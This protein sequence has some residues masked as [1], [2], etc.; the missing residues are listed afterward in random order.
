MNAHTISLA[1]GI[2]SGYE[3]SRFA[4][5]KMPP[6]QVPLLPDQP[7][8]APVL[9]EVHPGQFASAL[10]HE[11]RNPLTTINLAVDLLQS[12]IKDVEMKI[13]L[14]IIMRSS[15]RI[16]N[17]VT[18]LLKYQQE[19]KAEAEKHSIHQLLE[20]VLEMAHD[21]ITLK[22]ITVRKEYAAEDCKIIMNRPE[23]KIALT[24]IVMNAIDAMIPGEGEL[25]LI[26]RSVFGKYIVRI[27]DNG[28]GISK[29]N[30]QLI[31]K[32]YFTSKPG[33]LGL[34]LA[35]T[36]DALRSNHIAVNVESEEG[37]GTSFIL[38]LDKIM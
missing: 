9:A 1:A 4:P 12:G 19:A 11:V 28:C 21:R 31:F 36:Y 13:Y 33:G 22:R 2:A 26:T 3:P 18:E 23:I 5:W 15:E 34:G 10:A 24:N 27:E 38:F 30:L 35:T 7:L 8:P 20:E 37:T 25:K 17:L 14:D 16:N 32:P 6:R 29:A